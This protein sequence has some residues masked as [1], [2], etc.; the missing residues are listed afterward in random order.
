MT[1]TKNLLSA[2]AAAVL[3]GTLGGSNVGCSPVNDTLTPAYT[4]QE[5]NIEVARNISMEGKMLHDDLD[6][7]LLLRPVSQLSY[8]NIRKMSP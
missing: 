8:W 3:L 2:A 1:K 4:L 5:H 6:H 7:L